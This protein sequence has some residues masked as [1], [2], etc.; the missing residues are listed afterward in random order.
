MHIKFYLTNSKKSISISLLD[1]MILKSKIVWIICHPIKLKVW[2][3]T[4][5]IK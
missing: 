4:I 1:L 2:I 3:F 5:N